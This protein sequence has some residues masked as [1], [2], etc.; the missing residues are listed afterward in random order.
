M[1]IAILAGSVTRT[2]AGAAHA[3][4]ELANG[5]ARLPRLSVYVY[6]YECDRDWLLPAVN[7]VTYR[8]PQRRKVVWRFRHLTAVA[9]AAAEMRRH[10][11]PP[12]DLCYSPTIVL[13]MAFRHVY[14]D[15]PIVS[16]TGAVLTRRER[17]EDAGKNF[18][19]YVAADALLGERIERRTYREPNWAH[20][21]STGLVARQREAYF[22]LPERFFHVCPL[23]LNAQRFTRSAGYANMRAQYGI[24]ESAVV[25]ITVS[26]LV[27][28]KNTEAVVHALARCRRNDAYLFVVGDG[29]EREPLARL[30]R[31]LGIA[32]RVRFVGHA[33]PAPFYASSDVF[34]LPSLIESFG[35]VYGEAM[36]MGLPCIGMRN[37]PPSVLSTAEDVIEDGTTGFCVSDLDELVQRLDLLTTDAD[38]RREMG[39]KSFEL[40][41]A[42]YVS[43]HYVNFVLALA[44]RQFGIEMP[45]LALAG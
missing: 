19:W 37:N 18:T 5:L 42:R 35:L 23:G 24:P 27:R 26:R 1:R 28:W 11:L 43:E 3:L 32:D 9:D 30:A 36:L 6:A 34:V 44:Q 41:R 39:Q 31:D 20:V 10:P 15:V 2:Q 14:P 17:R 12:I 40:A 33:D 16:H 29:E 13:P 22:G 45:S 7:V 4:V 8:A 21:V 38:R 25:A